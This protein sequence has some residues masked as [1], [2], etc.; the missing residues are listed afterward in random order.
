MARRLATVFGGSGFIGRHVVQR[1]ASEGWRVR[2]AVRDI[3]AAAFL[4]PLGDVGQIVPILADVT[5]EA[6][7]QLAVAGADLVINL[8]GVLY[9]SGKRSFQAIHVDGAARVAAAAAAAGVPALVHVSALGAK[10]D[11]PSAYARSK[12][13]GEVAVLQAFPKATILRPSVVFGP[14][15]GF[16]NRFAGLSTFT[17]ALPVFV[18]DGFKI[19]KCGPIPCGIDLFGSGGPKL[20]AV[21]VGD[22]AQAIVVAAQGGK[23]AGKTYELGGPR[24]MSFKEIIE[25]VLSATGRRRF[26]L[27]VPMGV[28]KIQ[29]AF[30]QLLPSPPLTTDQVK[31]LQADN[32]V[33]PGALDFS[34]LGISPVSAE[35]MVPTYLSRFKNPYIHSSIVA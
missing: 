31:L 1:L 18:T 7:V 25:L 11:S 4:K 13:A 6:S 30:L 2:V 35:V 3:E 34:E 29:A 12:A 5:H 19:K 22:V 8:V 24:V 20:Q 23:A 15:D 32:V 16:F 28:A 26:L 17:P 9:E 21:Y 14:E 10:A 27:P 33:E